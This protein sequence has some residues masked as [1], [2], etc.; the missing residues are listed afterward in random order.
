MSTNRSWATDHW[1]HICATIATNRV[2]RIY[3][4]GVKVD[5]KTGQVLASSILR[6][7][8]NL[9]T[10]EFIAQLFTSTYSLPSLR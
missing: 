6:G 1:S 8:I 10:A 9:G 2:G 5:E 3:R 4:D 7:D